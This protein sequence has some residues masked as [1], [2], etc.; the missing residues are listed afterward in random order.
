VKC[1][2]L[3]VLTCLAFASDALAELTN[4]VA[5]SA[6]V[7]TN[8]L[9]TTN[10]PVQAEYEQLMELDDAA[11]AEIDGWI[12]E[13][14][15]F[16]EQGGGVPREELLSRISQRREPVRKAYEDFVKRHPNHGDGRLAFASFLE[17]SGDISGALEQMLKAKEVDPTNP[18]AWNNLAN[19][20][21]HFGGVTNAFTHYERAIEL[22]P[23]E[24]VYHQN[25]GTTVF[26]FRKDVREHYGITEQQVFNKALML[27]SNALTLD[28]TNFLLATDIAM[29]YYGIKPP[30]RDDAMKAWN[31]ALTLAESD[32]AREGVMIHLARTEAIATNFTKAREY[33]DA[34]TNA[35]LQELKGRVLRSLEAKELPQLEEEVGRRR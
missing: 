3:A 15:K 5:A 11:A 35:E 31:Y 28:P 27:Y 18:A 23:K 12:I 8:S 20:Y 13:N 7:R 25:F 32:L 22:D 33:L 4:A 29:T 16:E 19:Y 24:P 6:V 2:A 17:D 14:N 1:I 9:A 30:R 21:G 34:V 10:D 26:L